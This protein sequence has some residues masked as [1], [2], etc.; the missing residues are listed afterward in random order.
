MNDLLTLKAPIIAPAEMLV[1][2]AV[3]RVSQFIYPKA[4]EGSN[5]MFI[6]T[7]PAVMCVTKTI[8]TN[9]FLISGKESIQLK[10]PPVIPK[11]LDVQAKAMIRGII[12]VSP[13]IALFIPF[14]AKVT[15]IPTKSS[16]VKGER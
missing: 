10:P 16:I 11:T 4:K 14:V 7:S 9:L 3:S 6:I 5:I 12:S 8:I 15:K 2:E 1:S 13:I